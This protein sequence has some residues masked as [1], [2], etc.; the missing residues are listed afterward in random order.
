MPNNNTARYALGAH[1]TGE[2]PIAWTVDDATGIVTATVGTDDTAIT[3][4]IETA[5]AD[6]CDRCEVVRTVYYTGGAMK[7]DR[8]D[9]G[10]ERSMRSAKAD[11]IIEAVGRLSD[12]VA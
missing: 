2:T 7:R 11:A 12:G 6:A 5:D 10:V 9:E 4:T 3:L 1:L 8:V